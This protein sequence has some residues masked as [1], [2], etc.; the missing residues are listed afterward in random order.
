MD[1]EMYVAANGERYSGGGRWHDCRLWAEGRLGGCRK[2]HT[3]KRTHIQLS[4]SLPH[5]PTKQIATAASE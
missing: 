4:D 5:P 2:R 1:T 3:H